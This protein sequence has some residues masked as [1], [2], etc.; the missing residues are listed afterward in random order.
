MHAPL[1]LYHVKLLGS[2]EYNFHC[3]THKEYN[4]GGR[5]EKNEKFLKYK[6]IFYVLMTLSILG[7]FLSNA[8]SAVSYN[9]HKFIW[10]ECI[11]G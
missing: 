8:F 4:Q 2:G 9:V 6:T 10:F 3:I 7:Y 5:K 11:I 1:F